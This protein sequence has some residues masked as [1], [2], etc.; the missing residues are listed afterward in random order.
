MKAVIYARYSS[1]NQREESIEG[2]LRVCHEYARREGFDVIREYTDSAMTGTSDQRPSFQQL[3]ADSSRNE[4]DT[5]LVYTLDRFAR[6]RY[7]AAVYRKKLADNGARIVSVTQPIEDSPEGA[8]LESLL[9]GLAEYYSKNLARGVKR[10]MRENALKC[11]SVGGPTPIGYKIDPDTRKYVIDEGAAAIVREIFSL[12]VNG[13]GIEDILRVCE[14]KGYRLNSG[15]SFTRNG[16]SK[17]LRNRKYAGVY[18]YQDII[19]EGGM[20]AIIDQ[21]TFD[22]VQEI[23]SMGKRSNPRKNEDVEFILTGK[24]FCGHCGKPMVGTSGTSKSGKVHYYYHCRNHGNKCIKQAE[25]KDALE[26]FVVD[27]IVNHFLT[28]D[29]VSMIAERIIDMLSRDEFAQIMQRTQDQIDE[30]DR[31]ASNLMKAIE[32]DPEVTDLFMARIKD[33]QKEKAALQK[34]LESQQ[35]ENMSFLTKELIMAWMLSFAE[36]NDGSAEFKRNLVSTFVNAI[37]VYDTDEDDPDDKG[38]KKRKIVL[39]FNSSGPESKVTLECADGCLQGVRISDTMDHHY[40][41]DR[42]PDV[43]F[44]YRGRVIVV[45]VDY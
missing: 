25:K 31:R 38:R 44:V 37:Y 21:A 39:A 41:N 15:K 19:I 33:L 13:S 36:R 4:F 40:G 24:L 43:Y 23:I 34:E 8:L 28:Y 17:M 6:D 27:Y 7:D 18:I 11:M 35:A 45:I 20:P 22:K 10:G 9:E 2:Q 5:V 26:E 16:I 42:T 3:I 29:N 32:K 14:S 1:H 12:Y 30:I